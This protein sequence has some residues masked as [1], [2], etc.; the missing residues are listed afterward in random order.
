MISNFPV[1]GVSKSP[2]AKFI[3]KYRIDNG[4]LLGEMAE[5][6]GVGS[7]ELSGIERGKSPLTYSLISAI[8]ENYPDIDSGE[9]SNA[10][11]AS[12]ITIMPDHVRDEGCGL[13]LIQCLREAGL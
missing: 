7:A 12:R 8:Q 2:F 13:S 1:L 5:K 4:L 9:L 6:L 10:I 3:Q 11:N